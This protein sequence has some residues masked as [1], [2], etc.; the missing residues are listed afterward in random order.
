MKKHGSKICEDIQKYIMNHY[1]DSGLSLLLLADIYDLNP[2]YLSTLFKKN[3][4]LG[5]LSFIES[6][7]ISKAIE[8]LKEGEHT[9]G[10]IADITGFGNALRFRRSFKKS[11]GVNPSEYIKA[12][13]DN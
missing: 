11:T 6:V 10:E 2:S 9:I 8:L 4:G 12:K 5:I 3:K 13:K 7:R 1:G